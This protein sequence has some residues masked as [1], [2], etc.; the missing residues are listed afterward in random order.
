MGKAEWNFSR[1]APILA[2]DPAK[3]QKVNAPL[4]PNQIALGTVGYLDSQTDLPEQSPSFVRWEQHEAMV[5]VTL[6]TGDKINARIGLPHMTLEFGQQVAVAFPD[7]DPTMGVIFAAMN[8]LTF[9]APDSVAGVSTGAGAAT[10][11]GVP[12][13]AATWHFTRLEPGRVLAMQTGSGGDMLFCSGAS[14]ELKVN[15]GSGAVH[16]NGAVYMGVGPT[17]KPIG[18]TTAPGGEEIPGVPLVPHVPLPFKPAPPAG[19]AT[20]PYVGLADGLVRAH[21]AYETNIAVDPAFWAWIIGVDGVVRGIL[22]ALP[23]VPTNLTSVIS[24]AGGPGSKHTAT[25]DFEPPVP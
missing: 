15:P 8:D 10:D 21:D 11:K 19:P 13:P 12:I 24:G 9:P 18:S 25:G 2:G 7:G 6:T 20:T 3:T 22:P 16:L 1:H 5:E 17:S 23:V 4:I 14:M